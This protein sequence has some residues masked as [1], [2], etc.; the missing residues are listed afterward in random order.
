MRV[1][2]F[3]QFHTH[4][5]RKVTISAHISGEAL[6]DFLKSLNDSNHRIKD[7]D[8]NLVSPCYSWSHVTCLDGHV[9]SV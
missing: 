1:F 2:I 5:S 4:A 3:L 8:Y 6:V 7:W 9:V